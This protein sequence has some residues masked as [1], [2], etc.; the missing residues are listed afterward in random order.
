MAGDW[1]PIFN[2]L[3][4]SPRV[5]R[6]ARELKC[7]RALIV[8]ACSIWWAILDDHGT[9]GLVSGYGLEELDEEV[10]VKGFGDAMVSVGWIKVIDG[11]LFAPEW[12]KHNSQ[13]AKVRLTERAKKRRQRSEKLCPGSVPESAG[14]LRDKDGTNEGQNGDTTG[15]TTTTTTTTTSKG[16]LP[17]AA[18]QRAPKGAGEAPPLIPKPPPVNW[19]HLTG[20][21]GIDER[22]RTA[23]AAAY[24]ACDLDRQLAAMHAWLTAN[25]ERARKSNYERFITNWLKKEQDHGGD[26]RSNGNGRGNQRDSGTGQQATNGTGHRAPRPTAA[27]ERAKREFP[28]PPIDD[29]LAGLVYRPTGGGGS[30]PE[31][32]RA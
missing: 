5:V 25:P 10:Q 24:P 29:M 15:T 30:P 11:G 23:W 9:N 32:L 18:A 2:N 27:E 17:P 20:W 28:E 19:D 6:M 4:D 13:G 31:A 12:E 3:R 16:I 21:R 14:Q 26:M 1:H 8:G 22:R 7:K